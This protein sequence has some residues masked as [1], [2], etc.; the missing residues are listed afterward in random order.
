VRKVADDRNQPEPPPQSSAERWCPEQVNGELQSVIRTVQLREASPQPYPLSRYGCRMQTLWRE[1]DL[2]LS[3]LDPSDFDLDVEQ[4]YWAP[5][6]TAPIG[7]DVLDR[8]SLFLGHA[9]I[10]PEPCYGMASTLSSLP[11]SGFALRFD[12][13]YLHNRAPTGAREGGAAP[14]P[15]FRDRELVIDESL[16]ITEPTGAN[17][18]LALPKFERPHFVWRDQRVAEQGC[19]S[20]ASTDST[21]LGTSQPNR[22]MQPY[23]LSPFLGGQGRVAFAQGGGIGYAQGTWNNLANYRLASPSLIDAATGG[24]VGAIAAPLLADFQVMPDSPLLP[25]GH[26]SVATG[27]NLWQVSIAARAAGGQVPRPGQPSF[28]AFSGGGTVSGVP[29]LVDPTRPEWS[30]AAGGYAASGARTQAAEGSLHWIMADFAKRQT[31]V[32]A[33]FVELLDPHRMPA[34]AADPRLGPYFGKALPAGML[35][36]FVVQSDPPLARMPDS[37]SAVA[38]FRGAGPVDTLSAPLGQPG[39]PWRAAEDR[40]WP[41]NVPDARNF[42]LDPLK[43]GDAHIRKLDDRKLGGVA[44]DAWTYQY[45][46]NLTTWVADPNGLMDPAFTET[47]AGPHEKFLPK[48]VA[49]LGWRLVLRSDGDG[50]RPAVPRVRSFAVAWR[51]EKTE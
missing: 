26:P 15:A 13:N 28:R 45:N 44:R 10:R 8:T 49:Y 25:E 2:G 7:H 24:M 47:F 39:M 6:T 33:G 17:R 3:R 38:E 19:A 50:V 46:R 23:L 36:R 35:P 31:V 14:F 20:G 51:F 27:A 34:T 30:L 21:N 22:T 32:T 41:A 9:E 11:G 4:L 12:D 42:A 1:I 40:Y 48:D 29:K 16:A 37:T 18:F 43:A 5:L